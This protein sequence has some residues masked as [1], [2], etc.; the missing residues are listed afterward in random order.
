MIDSRHLPKM[1]AKYGVEIVQ[2]ETFYLDPA[3]EG[4]PNATLQGEKKEVAA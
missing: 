3:R 4:Q 1:L 2:G